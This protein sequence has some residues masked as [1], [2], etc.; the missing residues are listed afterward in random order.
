MDMKKKILLVED[1]RNFGAVLKDY[2]QLHGFEVTLCEDGIKGWE[3]F[4]NHSYDLCILD[5][6]MPKKD[7]FKLAEEIRQRN[8][9]IPILFLT[10]K[11]LREDVIKGY[12]TGAD[13]YIIKP[14]DTEVLLYKLK[15][16]LNRKQLAEQEP[17]TAHHIGTLVFNY[18]QRTLTYPD[19]TSVKLS[20]KE[21]ELL[22]LLCYHQEDVLP[23][24]KALK[25][26]WKEDN[27]FTGRSMDVFIVKLR[28]YLQ[29]DANLEIAS[30]HG[31]GY[32]LIVK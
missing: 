6:M 24:S 22:N 1:E 16:I 9:L 12:K 8:G 13:D 23:R 32:R 3:A 28:K 14:F 20:P 26:I 19:Q 11:S 27:Y 21:A 10:A 2:L 30:L 18:L 15:A 17:V 7:G 4:E 25:M 5:V 31:N 29:P